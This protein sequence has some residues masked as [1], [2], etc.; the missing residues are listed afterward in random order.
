MSGFEILNEDFQASLDSAQSEKSNTIGV[1]KVI[2]ILF[3]F[4]AFLIIGLNLFLNKIFQELI[5]IQILF[6]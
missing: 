1:P 4:F 5:L 6:L 2:N 3:K